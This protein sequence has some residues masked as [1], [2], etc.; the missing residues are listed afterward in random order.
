MAITKASLNLQ[1]GVQA[2]PPPL[3]NDDTMS[4]QYTL[5]E[6]QYPKVI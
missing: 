1:K 3:P 6:Q 4:P 2:A 5:D